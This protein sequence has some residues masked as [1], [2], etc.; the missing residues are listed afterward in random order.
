M[1]AANPV[2]RTKGLPLPNCRCSAAGSCKRWTW[3]RSIG[4][5]PPPSRGLRELRLLIPP[6]HL[7]RLRSSCKGRRIE[8]RR[9]DQWRPNCALCT[10][11]GNKSRARKTGIT[12]AV[13]GLQNMSLLAKLQ[14]LL[15]L[16]AS[17]AGQAECTPATLIR[18]ASGQSVLPVWLVN[19][20]IPSTRGILWAVRSSATPV[21]QQLECSVPCRA[22]GNVTS[23]ATVRGT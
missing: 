11:A 15:E 5:L 21:S 17:Y 3:R 19:G 8:R 6:A 1:L 7:H 9:R 18:E 12:L 13:S 20:F 2:A 23:K 10:T 14:L 16:Q 22:K 4:F